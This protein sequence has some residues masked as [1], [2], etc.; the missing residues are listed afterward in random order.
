[1]RYPFAVRVQGDDVENYRTLEEAATQAAD[2]RD[3]FGML[4][5]EIEIHNYDTEETF[6]LRGDSILDVDLEVVLEGIEPMGDDAIDS[7]E[8]VE[9]L[10]EAAGGEFRE[11]GRGDL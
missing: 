11:V 3:H 6:T 8:L 10:A 2:Q 5:G 4:E 1:M 9:K 7:G